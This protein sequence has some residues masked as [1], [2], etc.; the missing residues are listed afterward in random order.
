MALHYTLHIFT[1]RMHITKKADVPVA[2]LSAPYTK[3][4]LSLHHANFTVTTH[5]LPHALHEET[6]LFEGNGARLRR[7]LFDYTACVFTWME[8]MRLT[9]GL[10]HYSDLGFSCFISSMQAGFVRD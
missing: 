9:E 1:V 7:K 5:V 6:W 3:H 10:L 2:H 4:A 8:I